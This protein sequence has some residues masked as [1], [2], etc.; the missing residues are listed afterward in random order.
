M[1]C[2][3]WLKSSC[4]FLLAVLLTLNPLAAN[5]YTNSSG[6]SGGGVLFNP[7]AVM[8][9]PTSGS[10]L[11]GSTVTFNWS[12][13]T[14]SPEEYWLDVG[15]TPG[16]NNY[17][18]SGNLGSA[19]TATV[20]GLP[21]NGTTVY[22]TLYTLVASTWDSNSY[23]YTALNLSSAEGAVTTP[24]PGSTLSGSTVT[25]GWTAGSPGPYSYWLDVGSTSGG[26]NYYSSGNLGNVQSAT[27]T[28]LPTNG[29]QVFVTL[30]TLI[31]G[32]WY[33]N[34]YTYMALTL[35]TAEGV[36]TTPTPSSTLTGS[37]VTFD[38]TAGSPGPYSYW[39]DIGSSAGANNYYSSGNL[40]NVT[41]TRVTT[42]PTNGTQVYATLYTLISGSW[43]GNAYTYTALNPTADLAAIQT[44]APGT[45]LTGT[46]ATFTWSSDSNATAYWMDIGTTAGGN[47][48]YSSGSLGTA[49]TTTVSSLP[50]N[51]TTTLYVTLYSQVGGQWLSNTYTYTNY[52]GVTQSLSNSYGSTSSSYHGVGSMTP[53]TPAA[54]LAALQANVKYVF[55]VFQENRSF[56]HYYGTYPGANGLYATFPGANGSDPT[57]QPATSFSSFNSVIQ[58]VATTTGTVTYSTVSPFLLPREIINS[59]GDET[60]IYPEDVYSVDHSHTGYVDDLHSDQATRSVPKNDGYPL[61]QEALYY[62]TNSSGTSAPIYSTSSHAS[63]TSNATLQTKQK[64]EIVMGHVDCDT[65]PFMWQYADRFTLFDN[66]HQTAVGPSSPNAIALIGAETGDTQWVRHPNNYDSYSITYGS[67]TAVSHTQYSMPSVTDGAPFAGSASDNATTKPPYGPDE[68]SGEGSGT[69][70]TPKAGQETLTF[71]SL[72]LSFMGNQVNTITGADEHSSFDLT[73]ITQDMSTIAA[74]DPTIAWGWYQQG[75]GSEPFDGTAFN[76]DEADYTSAPEHASYIVHHNGPQFFGYLGDNTTEQGYM[77]SLGQFYTDVA[78]G[79]LSANGGV[80]YI[81]GGYYNNLSQIPVDPNS[82][83]RVDFTGNDDHGSYSDSQI[84]E[85]SVADTINAIANS[86]YW[87]QS[88][89]IITFDESDGFYDHQP[90]QFRTYGPDGEPETGG[91]RIPLLVVSPF[92]VTHG[93]SHTYS[94]HSSVVR[95]IEELEGLVPL[96]Q[97]PNEAA[98]FTTGSGLCTT[99]PTYSGSTV[100]PTLVLP[101]AQ[102]TSTSI[103]PFC[104]P[105]GSPQTALGPAD[106]Y[107]TMGDLTEAF[108]NDRLLGNVATL[109]ASYVTIGTYVNSPA[110]TTV[111][112]LPHYSA[113]GAC[114]NPALN[115]VPTDYI[116]GY[117]STPFDPTGTLTPVPVNDPPPADF[118]PRPT[119][120][121][122]S[123]YYNTSSNTTAN[124]PTGTGSPWPQ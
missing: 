96:G 110:T 6:R 30:Y 44:P 121:T 47:N 82:S 37:T 52:A 32:Q 60:T 123:P 107:S 92:A 14:A 100:A 45:P 3:T 2:H 76:D 49:L 62:D 42:L 57:T 105:N 67:P 26:N 65:I 74:N 38:W 72:P 8:T 53:L 24:T 94:E 15:S 36:L 118:N 106:I 35:S 61:D 103:N 23:T 120:S 29:T 19:L 70:G 79:N 22:A 12:A 13:G 104:L 84:S 95:F 112:T 122:G 5:A 39:L 80:Y 64:G 115:I 20:S 73:D 54:K 85:S 10:T 28:N 98:A 33:G 55:V 7:L 18:S 16:G 41:S 86:P 116:N 78:N 90:E 56:D 75:Y 31:D 124:S 9:S 17:Y 101:G 111:T 88:A 117:S 114:A 50:G 71:A 81:R 83:V 102:S 1:S 66:M 69:I 108:D 91:P 77:H 119:V 40:G 113:T 63:P 58:S 68:T 99:P 59:L 27:V 34:T 51:G 48:I 43:H 11:S 89:I 93:V 21:T 4:A 46:S 25:F 97:L 87:S 109:P